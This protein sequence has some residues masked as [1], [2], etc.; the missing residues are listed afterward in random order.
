MTLLMF[1]GEWGWVRRVDNLIGTVLTK[2]KENKD[3]ILEGDV[4][5]VKTDNPAIQDIKQK[6]NLILNKS[7]VTITKKGFH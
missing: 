3:P 7:N 2:D 4:Y 5:F 6:T 1:V